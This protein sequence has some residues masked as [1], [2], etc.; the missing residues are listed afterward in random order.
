MWSYC[1]WIYNYLCNQ[2]YHHSNCEF[3]SRTG[4]VYS[5]QHYVISL[6]VICGRSMVLFWYSSFLH[7][8]NWSSR[9][10]WKTVESGIKH[11]N[12]NPGCR[13]H[14]DC[15]IILIGIF[16]CNLVAVSRSLVQHFYYHIFVLF[17][18]IVFFCLSLDELIRIC[19]LLNYSFTHDLF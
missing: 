17:C 4:E 15:S 16:W 12:S 9:Y 11:H 6:S 2:C 1:G 10:N 5:I 19:E 3:E 18:Q 14:D 8:L 7:Q 13:V